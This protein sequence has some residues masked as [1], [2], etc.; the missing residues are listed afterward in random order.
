MNMKFE[1]LS[2]LVGE[3][4]GEDAAEKFKQ[5]FAGDTA[6]EF[7]GFRYKNKKGEVADKVVNIGVAY[8]SMQEKN[9]Q[10][11][12]KAKSNIEELKNELRPILQQ[13]AEATGGLFNNQPVDAIID[14]L[15]SIIEKAEIF[16]SQ[17]LSRAAQDIQA[18]QGS[19]YEPV[20]DSENKPVKGIRYNPSTGCFYLF[21]L[22]VSNKVV[23]GEADYSVKSK[24][25]VTAGEKFVR[26]YLKLL[27]PQNYKIA[28]SKI[29]GVK[30]RGNTI[31]LEG[32]FDSCDD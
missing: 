31:E 15:P 13:K 20:L 24:S 30:A 7:I 22:Q 17:A 3:G 10:K 8:Q 6:P 2:N 12:E 32:E 18:A 11:L 29:K 9:T 1:E 5:T 4:I 21:G 26:K 16:A 14:A 25:P 23:S 19:G 28:K 27:F